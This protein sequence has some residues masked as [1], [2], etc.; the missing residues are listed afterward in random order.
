MLCAYAH[1]LACDETLAFL[2]KKTSVTET[3]AIGICL[4]DSC[5]MGTCVVIVFVKEDL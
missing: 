3:F 2:E 4:L 5:V 1:M